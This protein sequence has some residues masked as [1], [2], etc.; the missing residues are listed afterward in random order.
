MDSGYRMASWFDT[1]AKFLLNNKQGFTYILNAI[2][3]WLFIF[4]V[5][6]PFCRG[7]K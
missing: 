7:M 2:R 5:L 3:G 4:L 1:D 6:A